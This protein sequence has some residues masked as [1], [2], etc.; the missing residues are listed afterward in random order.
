MGASLGIAVLMLVGKIVAYRLTGSAAIYSDALESVVHIAATAIP[1]HPYGHGKVAYF[2]SGVERALILVAA[3]AIGWVA[4][5]ALLHG[6]ELQRLGWGVAI[7]GGLGLVNLVLG[8]ALI[9]VG[10]QTNAV[11]L[12]ANGHH[13]LTDMWTSLGVIAGVAL[14]WATGLDW[15]DPVVALLLGANIVWTSTRLIREAV[16]GL[17]ERGDPDDTRRLMR[18]ST[19]R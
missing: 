16:R 17:M 19:T 1:E 13:V 3:V 12:V 8:L 5:G 9:R 10:R 18:C 6:V 2:S 15:L 4:A 11:V 7:T 14:V